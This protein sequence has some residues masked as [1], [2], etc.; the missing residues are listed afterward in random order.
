MFDVILENAT[1]LCDAHMAMLRLNE[2]G[3]FRRVANRGFSPAF[4][5][6]IS[7]EGNRY[8]QHPED[9]PSQMIV[10][11]QSIHILDRRES[12]IYLKGHPP[13]VAMVELG[14]VRTILAVP[15]LKEEHVIG[16][17]VLF[18]QEV[19]AFTQKQIDLVS[20]FANQAVIAIENVRLFNEIQDKSR[21]LEVA[22][23]HKSEF[24][25]NMSHECCRTR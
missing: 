23:R 12:G 8:P 20:T 6:W 16:A 5:K 2:D 19:R 9:W 22:N 3:R 4:A 14:S 18:R 10:E 1:R 17:I 7:E 24:L 21:E 25:A 11:K 13:T 15:M